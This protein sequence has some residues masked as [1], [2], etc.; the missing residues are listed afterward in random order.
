MSE[1]TTTPELHATDFAEFFTALWHKDPL[2]LAEGTGEA[3]AGEF[4]DPLGGIAGFRF[5]S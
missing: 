4:G 1:P 3:S 5:S 2:R